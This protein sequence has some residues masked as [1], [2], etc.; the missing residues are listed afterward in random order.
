[1]TDNPLLNVPI[2][3]PH[4]LHDMPRNL[5]PLTTRHTHPAA[6]KTADRERE[7]RPQV[8]RHRIPKHREA[9]NRKRCRQQEQPLNEAHSPQFICLA[10]SHPSFEEFQEDVHA[11]FRVTSRLTDKCWEYLIETG[12]ITVEND[13]TTSSPLPD[14]PFATPIYYPFPDDFREAY[15]HISP[16]ALSR[17]QKGRFTLSD[18]LQL[19]NPL[20]E[21]FGNLP[22]WAIGT[23][24]NRSRDVDEDEDFERDCFK[25]AMLVP[26]IAPLTKLW[27]AYMALSL[28]YN[29]TRLDLAMGLTQVGEMLVELDHRYKW[30][31]FSRYFVAMCKT[32][33]NK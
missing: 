23:T 15:P 27:F 12:E 14:E 33:F 4:I 25:F 22:S 6:H 18:F 16:E 2:F 5:S 10:V 8:V 1:M 26:S 3:I 11:R 19:R 24:S 31:A 30:K 7:T 21:M 20:S 29:P 9:T 32:C 17:F 13:L 28:H